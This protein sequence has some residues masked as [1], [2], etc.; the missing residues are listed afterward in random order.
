[1]AETERTNEAAMEPSAATPEPN[2]TAP[3]APAAPAPPRARAA[4]APRPTAPPAG[5]ASSTREQQIIALLERV[6]RARFIYQDG[7]AWLLRTEEALAAETPLLAAYALLTECLLA[8]DQALSPSER[9]ELRRLHHSLY[10]SR[11]PGATSRTGRLQ[12]R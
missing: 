1:M 12:R 3:P 7:Q 9:A 4:T 11:E 5:A 10:D 2:V 8:E 6:A